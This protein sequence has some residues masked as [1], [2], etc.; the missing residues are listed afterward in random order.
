MKTS[1][2]EIQIMVDQETRAWDTLD[3]EMLLSIFHPDMVWPWPPTDEDHDPMKWILVLGKFNK[4][5][6]E[7]FYQVFFQEHKLLHNRRETKKIAI[8]EEK[9]GAF[10]VVDIDTLWVD[11]GGQEH[12]WLGRV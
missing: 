7:K 9:D 10:A 4:E 5:R 2:K 12:H 8:S 3:V 1:K 6:W 11:A